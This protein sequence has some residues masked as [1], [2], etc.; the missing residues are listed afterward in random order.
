MSIFEIQGNISLKDTI[1]RIRV[2]LL[3]SR[4]DLGRFLTPRIL[5]LVNLVRLDIQ[6]KEVKIENEIIFTITD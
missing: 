5:Q 4:V 2:W 3:R 1:A 6:V